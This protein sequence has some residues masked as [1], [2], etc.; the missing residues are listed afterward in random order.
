MVA[1]VAIVVLVNWL[2][3]RFV[4]LLLPRSLALFAVIGAYYLL[5]RRII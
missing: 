1:F 5:A 3:Y 4:A 2:C